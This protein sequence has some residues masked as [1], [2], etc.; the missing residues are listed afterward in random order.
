[1]NDEDRQRQRPCH[2]VIGDEIADI[3]T[4]LDGAFSAIR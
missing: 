1:M 3:E 2:A 4:L